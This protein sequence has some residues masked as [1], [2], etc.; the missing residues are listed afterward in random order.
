MIGNSFKK[1]DNK[2]F[3]WINKN[4]IIKKSRL[5]KIIAKD[6]KKLLTK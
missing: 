3:L 4:K 5:L 2:H 1:L 6:F